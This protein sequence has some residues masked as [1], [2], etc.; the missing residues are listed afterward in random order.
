M[1]TILSYTNAAFAINNWSELGTSTLIIYPST[2]YYETP[3][4]SNL[5]VCSL[6]IVTTAQSTSGQTGVYR[7][8]VLVNTD[9]L[10]IQAQHYHN[11][12]VSSSGVGVSSEITVT[13]TGGFADFY[14]CQRVLYNISGDGTTIVNPSPA[15]TSK[16]SGYAVYGLQTETG[17]DNVYI[18]IPTNVAGYLYGMANT[19]GGDT[20]T[21]AGAV[22]I[23]SADRAIFITQ[24][25]TLASGI[26][27]NNSNYTNCN[28]GVSSGSIY[29]DIDNGSSYPNANWSICMTA[30]G[31]LS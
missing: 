29:A 20:G 3:T 24:F 13:T 14:V 25:Y 12:S 6:S 30:G 7:A 10:I 11:L 28:L 15:I 19:Y 18:T 23:P 2:I 9:N 4:S 22:T 17:T 1:T 8:N 27:L 31:P 26:T 5:I 16:V 21:G